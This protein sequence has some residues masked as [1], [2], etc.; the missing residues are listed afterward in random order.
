MHILTLIYFFSSI[1]IPIEHFQNDKWDLLN[2]FVITF[3]GK[4]YDPS[5]CFR[6]LEDVHNIEIETFIP[7]KVFCYMIQQTTVGYKKRKIYY[8][9]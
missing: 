9:H 8:N 1:R 4:I 6:Q 7:L 5:L 3:C 2:D